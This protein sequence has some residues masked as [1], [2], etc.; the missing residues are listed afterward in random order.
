MRRSKL[1]T[2]ATRARIVESASR[3][4][5]ANGIAATGLAEVMTAANL[6]NGG[7]YRHFASKEALVTEACVTALDS[8]I[9]RLS[10]VAT[11]HGL[12]GLAAYYL[13]IGHRD[14]TANGCPLA[15]LGA[16]LPRT[17]GP[18]RAAAAAG[19]RALTAIIAA[20]PGASEQSA[21]AAA[22]LLIGAVTMARAVDE[23]ALSDAILAAALAGFGRL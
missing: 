16:E 15:A 23:P 2:A 18:T 7:F 6:T 12:P 9:H 3:A 17:Q 14:D 13:S 19:L 21:L 10:A 20:T 22:S 4:F 1:D 5:R 8:V 11:E